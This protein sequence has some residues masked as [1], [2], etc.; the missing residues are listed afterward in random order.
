M[1]L[2]RVPFEVDPKVFIRKNLQC[3]NVNR[4]QKIFKYHLR[5]E[6]F[7]FHKIF[8]SYKIFLPFKVYTHKKRKVETNLL[9]QII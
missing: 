7:R 8:Q 9:V 3:D 1:I 4:E 5:G 6:D 2:F